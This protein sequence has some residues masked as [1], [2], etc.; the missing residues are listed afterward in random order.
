MD[1]MSL[2]LE[3]LFLAYVTPTWGRSM[4]HPSTG[5]WRSRLRGWRLPSFR[6][7]YCVRS[8]TLGR[9]GGV[10]ITQSVYPMVLVVD[11]GDE[12][13]ETFDMIT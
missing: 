5:G 3:S 12:Y 4:T 7:L 9:L 6:I 13:M 2:R 1:L 8:T 11:G 10:P